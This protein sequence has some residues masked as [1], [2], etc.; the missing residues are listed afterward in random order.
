[1][2]HSTDIKDYWRRAWGIGDRPQFNT[3][4]LVKPSTTGIRPGYKG[5]GSGGHNVGL[6]KESIY[7]KPLDAQ[8][9][10]IAKHVY[11]TIDI[12]DDQRLRIVNGETTMNT[13]PVKWKAGDISVKSKRGQPVTDVVFK[14]KKM[15]KDFIKYLKLRAKQPLKAVYEYGNEWF[16][17]NFPISKKQATRAIPYLMKKHNIKYIDAPKTES[18]YSRRA[19]RQTLKKTSSVLQE[20]RIGTAKTKILDEL[21]LKKKIDFAHRVSKSHMA[22]LGLQFSSD[23]VGMDSR[24]IN[25]VI[26][27]PAE[28]T[29]NKLYKDQ[30]K[31]FEE[32]KNN[33][34][35]ELRTKLTNL[36]KEIKKVINTTS[37]RLVGVT[38]DPHTLEPSFEGVKKKYSLTKFIGANMTLKELEK[39]SPADQQKF[40]TKQLTNAVNAEVKKGFVP[41]DF[42]KILTDSKS[43]EAILK[44][45]KKLGPAVIKQLQWA[46]KNPNSKVSMKLL[47]KLSATEGFIAEDVLKKLSKGKT[48]LEAAASPLFLDKAV[49]R[50]LKRSKADDQQNLAYD[51]ANLLR[52]VEEGKADISNIMHMAMKDP[53]FKGRPGEYVE[54]LKMVVSDPHQQKLIRERDIETEEALILP[55]EKV[56]KRKKRYE[57]WKSIPVVQAVEEYITPDKQKEKVEVKKEW[58]NKGGLTGVDQYIINRG[59]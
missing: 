12:T 30:L 26:V 7:Y 43:R 38:I 4:Q 33:P 36:N 32:L 46:F 31:I 58:L 28:V 44:Y 8:G 39:L 52:F 22:K 25:Q 51:R 49:H 24:I 48:M 42:K 40:L 29:L 15:E 13:K 23:L 3:G 53:D 2:P 21:D 50:G 41:N 54:W 14:N 10:K 34:T 35:D 18:G 27:K 56:A 1:M 59:I 19:S 5:P 16:S 57:A 20:G 11:G 55:A 45:A 37:G 9:E 17:K 6:G 47:S